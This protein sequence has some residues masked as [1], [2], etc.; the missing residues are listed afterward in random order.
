MASLQPA[1]AA[2]WRG[3]LPPAALPKGPHPNP[4]PR[5]QTTELPSNRARC[6]PSH[7]HALQRVLL[8]GVALGQRL[9]GAQRGVAHLHRH[10]VLQIQQADLRGWVRWGWVSR[11]RA[12]KGRRGAVGAAAPTAL[13]ARQHGLSQHHSS[14]I[15][16]GASPRCLAPRCLAPSLALLPPTWHTFLAL[17]TSWQ[18]MVFL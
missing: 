1:A 18:M 17:A 15:Q 4:N 10:A 9:L 16:A 13:Q 11:A 2:G 6:A 7:L 3:Q 8:A 12:R 14:G 5:P